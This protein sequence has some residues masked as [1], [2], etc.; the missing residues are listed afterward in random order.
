MM[1]T[2]HVEYERY[3]MNFCNSVCFSYN[4]LTHFSTG[5]EHYFPNTA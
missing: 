3:A 5:L 2:Q 4:L 1:H